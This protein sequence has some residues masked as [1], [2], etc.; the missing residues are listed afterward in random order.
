MDCTLGLMPTSHRVMPRSC[1][2]LSANSSIFNAVYS[3][4]N[5]LRQ[6]T[7]TTRGSYALIAA[8]IFALICSALAK[9]MRPSGR[10]ISRP[11]NCSSRGCMPESGRNTLVSRLR[12]STCTGGSET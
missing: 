9:N 3:R 10:N 5:T 12:P 2:R 4:S 8:R 11:G 1:K 7:I 6:S